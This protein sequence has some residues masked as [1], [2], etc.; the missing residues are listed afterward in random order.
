M[1]PVFVLFSSDCF[2]LFPFFSF[3]FQL[4][5]KFIILHLQIPYL[6]EQMH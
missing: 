2:L 4:L 6:F 5:S 3:F 1:Q